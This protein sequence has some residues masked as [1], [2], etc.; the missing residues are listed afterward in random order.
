LGLFWFGWLFALTQFPAGDYYVVLNPQ[1]SEARFVSRKL[2]TEQQDMRTFDELS[3]KH[4]AWIIKYCSGTYEYPLYLVWYTDTDEK[5]TDRLLTYKSG[6][7]FAVKSLAN[8]KASILSVLNN[9]VDFENLSFWLDNFNDLEIKESCS[10]NLDSVVVSIGNDN[11]DLPTIEEFTNFIN[12]FS[13]FVNQDE[14]NAHFQVYLDSKV[15]SETWDYYYNN[16]FWPRYSDREKFEALVRP[17]LSIDTKELSMK[18][19]E[20]IKTFDDNI[21]QTEKVFC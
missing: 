11:L 17:K 6:E 14:K 2:M 16:I 3:E 13:D 5:S 12:L 10:Y 19:K 4:S 21:K 7:I 20:V 15:I 9:L 1:I 18:L 8:L